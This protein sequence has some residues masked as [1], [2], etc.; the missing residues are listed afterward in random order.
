MHAHVEPL[1]AAGGL[2]AEQAA[3]DDHAGERT[4]ELARARRDEGAQRLD[5]VERAVDEASLWPKPSTARRA[6]YDPVA[7]TRRS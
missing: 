4:T 5:V 6:A 2:E 7:R 1:E 3:A